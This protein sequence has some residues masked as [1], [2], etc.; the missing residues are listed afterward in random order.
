MLILVET[1]ALLR[2]RLS[3]VLLLLGLSIVARAVLLSIGL[4]HLGFWSFGDDF[5]VALIARVLLID[6]FSSGQ[7]TLQ[8]RTKL[9]KLDFLLRYPSFLRRALRIRNIDADLPEPSARENTIE[10]RMVRFRYGPWDPAYY[11]VLGSLLGRGLIEAIPLASE[12]VDVV[13]SNCVVNLSPE[14]DRV[15]AE[16]SRVLRP[17]GRIGISDVVAEDHLT[18]AE[19]AERG[20]YVG[21]IAG[22]LSRAEYLDGLAAAGFVDAEVEFTHEAVP[23]MHGAIIR[24]T[25]PAEPA[26]PVA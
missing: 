23:G 7:G 20:S 3:G 4:I 25:K 18:P 19:R 15:L 2:I 13:I 24:A 14:K 17:G 16:I 1:K 26:G 10:Q 21:C 22:A 5:H 9:A 6:A 8:G 12:S 11:A